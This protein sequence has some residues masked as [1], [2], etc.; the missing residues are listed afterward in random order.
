MRRWTG[1]IVLVLVAAAAATGCGGGGGK[2]NAATTAAPS[3]TV[4]ATAA[5]AATATATTPAEPATPAKAG[6]VAE[7]AQRLQKG[8]YTVTKRDVNP[9]AVAERGV[10]NNVLVIEYADSAAAKTGAGVLKGAVSDRP[11][12]AIVDTE[13][14]LV[15]FLGQPTPITA[16]ERA[17]FKA[18]VD[19]GEGR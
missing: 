6:S 19:V 15:Y 17:A 12:R 11:K 9:P 13:D 5:P 16:K 1:P 10:G 2:D 4:A 3:K 18:L 14:R 8:G 7:A